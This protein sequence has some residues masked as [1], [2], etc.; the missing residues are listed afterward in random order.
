MNKH[1]PQSPETGLCKPGPAP[2]GQA[3]KDKRVAKQQLEQWQTLHPH[4]LP[5]EAD[6]AARKRCQQLLSGGYGAI[7][8]AELLGER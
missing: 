4:V 6:R 1:G 8:W 7:S 2:R 5:A 3:L